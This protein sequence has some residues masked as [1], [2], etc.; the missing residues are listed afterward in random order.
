MGCREMNG[1][2]VDESKTSHTC[3]AHGENKTK[4]QGK[5]THSIN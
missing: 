3:M 4:P 5:E 2:G 1:K